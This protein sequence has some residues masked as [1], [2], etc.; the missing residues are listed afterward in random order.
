MVR[1]RC[2]TIIV[3]QLENEGFQVESIELGKV[4]VQG[5]IKMI[6]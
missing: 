4:V 3:Q 1:N 2:K 6:S 5:R